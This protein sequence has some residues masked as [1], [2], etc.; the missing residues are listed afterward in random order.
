M[1]TISIQKDKISSVE[2][3]NKIWGVDITIHSFGG[4]SIIAKNFTGSDA[5]KIHELLM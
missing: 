3:D 1:D 2:L 4:T 5:K